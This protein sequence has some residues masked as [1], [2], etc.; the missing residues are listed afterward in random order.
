MVWDM[1]QGSVLTCPMLKES[2]LESVPKSRIISLL[3][4]QSQKKCGA[5]FNR[6]SATE[7]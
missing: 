6:E 3:G 1:L 2:L 5:R 4:K 7:Y